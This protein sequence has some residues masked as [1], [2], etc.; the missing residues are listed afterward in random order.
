MKIKLNQRLAKFGSEVGYSEISP[1]FLLR[2][3]IWVIEAVKAHKIQSGSYDD[4][5]ISAM[6]ATSGVL[7]NSQ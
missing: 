7:R 5:I 6:D 4:F 3:A 1:P 2:I